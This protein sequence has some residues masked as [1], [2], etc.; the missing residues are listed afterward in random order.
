MLVEIPTVSHVT[1]PAASYQAMKPL[2]TTGPIV[3]PW[4]PVR[5]SHDHSVGVDLKELAGDLATV[6]VTLADEDANPATAGNIMNP[7]T[8]WMLRV[9]SDLD[10][11]IADMTTNHP[12]VTHVGYSQV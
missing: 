3:R 1:I 2:T 4:V 8:G 11:V 6:G 9:L 5:T 10:E 12:A 7:G